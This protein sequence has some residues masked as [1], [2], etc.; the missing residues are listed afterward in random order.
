MSIRGPFVS[1]HHLLELAVPLKESVLKYRS[2]IAAISSAHGWR[3]GA[4]FH[5]IEQEV[6]VSTLWLTGGRGLLQLG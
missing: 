2:V 1:C 4:V 3:R 6:P 5:L